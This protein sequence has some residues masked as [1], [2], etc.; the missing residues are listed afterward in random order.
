MDKE[1]A[2]RLLAAHAEGLIG[3]REAMQQTAITDAE[4]EELGPLFHLAEHLHQSMTPIQPSAVFVRSMGRELVNNARRQVALTKRARKGLLIGAAA[5]GSL[6]SL[7]SLIGA[8]VFVVVRWR[9][10]SHARTAHA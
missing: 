8:I 3:R 10:R 1:R 4:R 6:V 9:A 2:A 5:A 7:A